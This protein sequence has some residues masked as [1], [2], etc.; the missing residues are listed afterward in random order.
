MKKFMS[1]ALLFVAGLVG[2]AKIPEGLWYQTSS[3]AGDCAKCT[4]TIKYITPSIFLVEAN[5]NWAGFAYYDIDSD[6]YEGVMEWKVDINDHYKPYTVFRMK[7]VYEGRTLNLYV[8]DYKH[9][10]LVFKVT[11]RHKNTIE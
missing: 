8:Y 1:V 6:V 7:F 10:K 5:N 11:Y 4:I 2:A 9:Q 3:T